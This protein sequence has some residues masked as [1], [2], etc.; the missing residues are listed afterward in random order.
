MRSVDLVRKES[1]SK[2]WNPKVLPISGCQMIKSTSLF[3]HSLF[4]DKSFLIMSWGYCKLFSSLVFELYDRIIEQMML[5]ILSVLLF[6][7]S[8][9]VHYVA[10]QLLLFTSPLKEEAVPATIL[11]PLARFVI[12]IVLTLDRTLYR[13]RLFKKDYFDGYYLRSYANWSILLWYVPSLPRL[14]NNNNNT[15]SLSIT[16][17]PLFFAITLTNLAKIGEW[18]S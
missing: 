14:P 17:T 5:L 16:F 6:S 15:F 3:R 13:N 18:A 10:D 8:R 4:H 7:Y 12:S 2:F 1:V 9:V 11:W